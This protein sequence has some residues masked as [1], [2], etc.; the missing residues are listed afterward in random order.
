MGKIEKTV[1]ISYRRTDISWALAVYQNLTAN[2]YDVFFDYESILAGDFEQIII[3]NIKARAH[4][5]VILTPKALDRCSEPG[6][7]LRREIETAI[8]EKR[9]IV[10]LFFDGFD[11]GIPLI[12]KNLSGKLA[13]LKKYNGFYVYPSYFEAAMDKLRDSLNISLD[14]ILHPVSDEVQQVVKE[15]QIAVKQKVIADLKEQGEKFEGQDDLEAALDTYKEIKKLDSEHPNIDSKIEDLTT[16]FNIHNL[17]QESEDAE[18][19]E[20]YWSLWVALKKY[21]QIRVL[22]PKYPNI[23][24]KVEQLDN[25]LR[26]IRQKFFSS[27]RIPSLVIIVAGM[28]FWGVYYLRQN[29]VDINIPVASLPTISPTNTPTAPIP[30]ENFTPTATPTP[31]PNSTKNFTPELP[32]I[33]PS[34]TLEI[35]S[36]MTSE[37]DG[38]VL[39]YVPAGEFEMGSENG[40][41]DEMP[42]HSVYLDS[43]WID[44]TEV[45]NSMFAK[46]LTEE[47][48]QWIDFNN[49]C[50]DFRINLLDE[51]W[52]AESEF[53]NHPVF[54]TSWNA[55]DA[56]CNWVGR[57]LPTEAEWEKAASWDM[58]KN[59]KLIYPWGNITNCSFA[60]YKSEDKICVGDTVAVMSYPDGVS[61]YGAYDMAG[62]V[63]EWMADWY[64][65]SYYQ[66]SPYINPMGPTSGPGRVL[67]GGAWAGSL[68]FDIRSSNRNWFS[69]GTAG[70]LIGFRCAMDA[71][72]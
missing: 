21:K 54:A 23:D 55:A 9:N 48:N 66:E 50:C 27:L 51:I 60:N 71:S 24:T 46:F 67:R 16:K 37:K 17:V 34:S 72:D 43:Y 40:S 49:L 22:D 29:P 11:F 18:G 1:F 26:I 7:W 39:V 25:R 70:N 65:G 15:Q 44:Q 8:D 52:Q 63:I 14:A 31:S 68:G 62:N 10:P 42:V 3:G 36:T 19:K 6:D 53:E 20:N 28:I 69:P 33:T 12:S 45:T 59:E 35:G 13:T 56:Y 38:M 57:R 2:G 47:G 32:T 61:P 41:G 5:I 30:T 4:F 64:S 58:D